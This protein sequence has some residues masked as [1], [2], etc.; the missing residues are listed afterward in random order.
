MT[1]RLVWIRDWNAHWWSSEGSEDPHRNSGSSKSTESSLWQSSGV[2]SLDLLPTSTLCP[3]YI[4]NPAAYLLLKLLVSH[5]HDLPLLYESHEIRVRWN[6][7]RMSTSE[8]FSRASWN[9]VY[10]RYRFAVL[11]SSSMGCWLELTTGWRVALCSRKQKL[12]ATDF[13]PK[14]TPH[15]PPYP[16]HTSQSLQPF[17]CLNKSYAISSC[18]LGSLNKNLRVWGWYQRILWAKQDLF[19]DYR[20]LIYVRLNGRWD[21]APPTGSWAL[22]YML[23]FIHHV[24][25]PVHHQHFFRFSFL[26]LLG[27][28]SAWSRARL[29]TCH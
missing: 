14:L 23:L 3:P 4:N 7:W 18:R 29:S 26:N 28:S 9:P 15:H 1:V 11:P 27:H 19:R 6:R 5:L 20:L 24:L 8:S 13:H 16:S 22:V 21:A 2:S 25:G 10:Q 12:V 17:I